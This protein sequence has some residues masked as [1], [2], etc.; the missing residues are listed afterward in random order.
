MKKRRKRMPMQLEHWIKA[1]LLLDIIS[2]V[3]RVPK[4]KIL[5]EKSKSE[6]SPLRAIFV[7]YFKYLY[8][9]ISQKNIASVLGFRY[10]TTIL[11]LEKFNKKIIHPINGCT[12]L[13]KWYIEVLCDVALYM[14]DLKNIKPL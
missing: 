2:K 10:H 9:R 11:N 8:P 12:P 5:T 3:S 14:P 7:V 4:E 6:Y 13:A 1:D